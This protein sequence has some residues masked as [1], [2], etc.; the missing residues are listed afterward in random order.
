VIHFIMGS[1]S[2]GIGLATGNLGLKLAPQ[3]QG[4]AYLANVTLVGALAGGLAALVGGALA[5]WFASRELA[6]NLHWASPGKSAALTVVQFQHW[7]FL[8]AISFTLGFYVMHALSRIKEGREH[9]ERQV[10]QQ[11]TAEAARTLDQLSTIE[12]LR[13]VLLFPF[14]R[15]VERRRQPRN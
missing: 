1:A 3:G 9:S 12:G 11:F 6:L 14:G 13:A 15:L 8:F 5:D 4:T 10:I 7:E 2:G